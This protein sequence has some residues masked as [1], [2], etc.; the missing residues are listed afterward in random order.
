MVLVTVVAGMRQHDV[1]LEFAGDALDGFLDLREL[2]REEPVPKAEQLDGALPAGAEEPAG[3][4]TSRSSF[5][6]A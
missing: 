2:G 4:R 6:P 1:R 5:W 3:R